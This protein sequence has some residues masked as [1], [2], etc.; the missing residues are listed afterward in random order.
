MSSPAPTASASIESHIERESPKTTMRDA[1]AGDDGE[2][3]RPGL[4]ADREAGDGR[5][6]DERADRG[7]RAQKTEP[8]RA[9]LED[10]LR[11]DRKQRDRP[12]EEHSEEIERDGAEQDVRPTDET[13]S[14]EH[15]VEPDGGL[16]C[17]LAT[18]P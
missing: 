3:H 1:E 14:C 12:A 4:A 15:L 8:R 11:E 9:D 17:R 7:R 13:N 5:G 16:R 6:R 10:V 18:A 2:E